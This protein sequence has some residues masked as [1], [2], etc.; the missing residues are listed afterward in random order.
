MPVLIAADRLVQQGKRM[1]VHL[2]ACLASPR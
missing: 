2:Q 1:G